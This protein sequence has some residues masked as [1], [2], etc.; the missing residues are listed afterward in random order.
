[1]GEQKG[2]RCTTTTYALRS[3]VLCGTP[4]RLIFEL[5]PKHKPKYFICIAVDWWFWKVKKG[6]VSC[7][8]SWN[9]R[10]LLFCISVFSFLL[11]PSFLLP[12][13]LPPP[14][15]MLQLDWASSVYL[16]F[17]SISLW[18]NCCFH[19]NHKCNL[20]SLPNFSSLGALLIQT[21]YFRVAK[22]GK[23][24]VSVEQ[25]KLAMKDTP[26]KSND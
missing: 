5:A 10:K 1:M 13:F 26:E 21:W 16:Q 20:Y 14:H 6:S 3:V 24:N 18:C 25:Q 15:M 7:F 22:T 12:S 4:R 17:P 19:H 9:R 8:I 2:V 23:K 11:N